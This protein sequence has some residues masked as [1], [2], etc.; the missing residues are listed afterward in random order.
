MANFDA[1]AS[2]NQLDLSAKALAFAPNA[3]GQA[4]YA[5]AAATRQTEYSLFV[6][7]YLLTGDVPLFGVI[8]SRRLPLCSGSC[9]LWPTFLQAGAGLASAGPLLAVDWV[10]TPL[11]LLRIDMST[12]LMINSK[13]VVAW[14]YPLWLG[15]TL[16]F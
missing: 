1:Q 3:G 4:A 11:S 6:N 13:R 8:Y 5:I 10:M 7:T 15:I 2:A 9:W 12:H 16:P 14:S